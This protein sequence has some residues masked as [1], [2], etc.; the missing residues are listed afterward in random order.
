MYRVI[1]K[2]NTIY[3][4]NERGKSWALRRKGRHLS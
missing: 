1:D 2:K 4:L 3:N